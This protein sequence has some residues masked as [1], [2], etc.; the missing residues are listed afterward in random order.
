MEASTIFF[1]C[2]GII[3]GGFAI[4]AVGQIAEQVK[5][6]KKERENQQEARTIS[7]RVKYTTG[8]TEQ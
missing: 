8:S 2:L 4:F 1:V 5:L 3:G 6:G 7:Q